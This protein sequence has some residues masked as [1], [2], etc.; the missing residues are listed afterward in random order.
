MNLNMD[1]DIQLCRIKIN[2]KFL[3]FKP[4]FRHTITWISL[5]SMILTVKETD[6]WNSKLKSSSMKWCGWVMEAY[7]EGL[8]TQKIVNL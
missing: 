8:E 7:N 5:E 3:R 2:F 6:I 1:F 4:K